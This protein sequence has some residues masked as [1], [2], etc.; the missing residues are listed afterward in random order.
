MS[1]PLFTLA[2]A[3]FAVVALLPL[4]VMLADV[5]ADDL[6]GVFDARTL[7][8]FGH[9]VLLG[10]S[11][12]ALAFAIGLPFGFLV[13]RTDLPGAGVLRALGIVPLVMPP[14]LLAMVWTY[15][16]DQPGVVSAI[17][18][19]GMSTFPLVALFSARAFE[20]IDARREEAA[21]LA[22]GLPAVLRMELPLVLPAALCGTCLAFSFAVND[23]AVPDFVTFMGR[24][25]NVYADT[26][27]SD[28]RQGLDPGRAVA[29][30]LPLIALTLLALIP[31]LALRR[32]GSLATLS[33]D[34]RTPGRLR[35][36]AWRWPALAFALLVVSVTCLIPIG[37]LFFEAAG[38]PV[39]LRDP[40]GPRGLAMAGPLWETLRTSFAQ[41]LERTREDLR[42]SLV[43][44]AL[45]ATGCVALGLVLGH[46][47]ERTR[48]PSL[49]K[50]LEVLALLPL[51]APAVLLGIG[52][53]VT[54]NRAATGFVY[55]GPVVVV[56]LYVA[57]YATFAVLVMSGAVASVHPSIEEAGAIAGAGPV[58]RLFRLVAPS[59]KGSLVGAWVLV[60][61]FAMREL[62]AAILVKEAKHTAVFRV[63]NSIHFG[64]DTFVAAMSLLLVFTIVLPGLLW[65]LLARRR[66]EVLP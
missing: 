32:R 45:A 9:T 57:R 1:R 12:A 10:G 33:G 18:V 19:L 39:L 14:L 58:A 41:A 38:G 25:F 55:D 63:F 5:G 24:K 34:F 62:D 6:V 46:A 23:F 28:W 7:R 49:G 47:V 60:F 15:L 3:T 40:D 29:T 64:R 50:A 37:D 48:R 66:L 59:L 22:G 36:R 8:L 26:I 30:S 16:A 61:V 52:I 42:N 27:M 44:S 31:A 21:L 17:A 43:Y 20:R 2:L 11:S 13:A 53:V 4:A 56:L 65:T 54:W 51:A 35:L